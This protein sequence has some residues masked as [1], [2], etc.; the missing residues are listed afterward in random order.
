MIVKNAFLEEHG[1]NWRIE[2]HWA[3]EL[4]GSYKW[5]VYERVD[6]GARGAQAQR[7]G[8]TT[9]EEV[10][11]HPVHGDATVYRFVW[12]PKFKGTEQQARDFLAQNAKGI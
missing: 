4:D 10:G 12:V 7:D 1:D 6:T 5:G 3:A 11:E 8:K 2:R 9:V